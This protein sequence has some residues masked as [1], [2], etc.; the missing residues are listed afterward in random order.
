M[1]ASS[2]K[3][4]A[5]KGVFSSPS[6]GWA[7]VVC[8][9]L[10]A[11]AGCDQQKVD[12]A[13]DVLQKANDTAKDVVDSVKP[14][15]LLFK[16]IK[17]GE[18]TEE[19]VRKSAGKPE[20]VRQEADGGKRLEYPRGPMGANTYF[21]TMDAAG[22]VQA[23]DQVLTAQNIAKIVPGMSKDEVRRIL[24]KPTQ[25][26]HFAL[27]KEDVW[28]WRWQEEITRQAMFNAHFAGGDVVTTTSRSETPENENR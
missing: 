4:S 5:R 11:L 6:A 20:T 14:D 25:I 21:V 2:R 18:S 19:D 9:A 1:S 12:Q 13:K 3:V 16:N 27:K 28:S 17:L 15:T 22:K 24:G 8:A 7:A 23:V 26:S 10:S